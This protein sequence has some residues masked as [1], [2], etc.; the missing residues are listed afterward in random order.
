MQPIVDELL[1]MTESALVSTTRT[2]IAAQRVLELRDGRDVPEDLTIRQVV[3]LGYFT[4]LDM[5]SAMTVT[6]Q[7]V[8]SFL[9]AQ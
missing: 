1:A 2:V 7:D 5:T 9:D 8:R 4:E 6:E 3:D